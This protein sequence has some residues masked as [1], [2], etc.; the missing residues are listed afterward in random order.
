MSRY[1]L[2]V[3]HEAEVKSCLRAIKV[4]LNTGSHFLTHADFG[5][6]D[7]VHKAWIVVEADNKDE[8]RNMLPPAY[9]RA[10]TIVEV[11]KFGLEEVNNL[12]EHHDKG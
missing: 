2:E 4:L 1:F 6:E 10:A 9:R 3:P 11:C 7:G 12:I 8:A 5:C